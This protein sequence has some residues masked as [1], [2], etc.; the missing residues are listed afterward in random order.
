MIVNI[1]KTCEKIQIYK[2]LNFHLQKLNH[3]VCEDKIAIQIFS[4]SIFSVTLLEEI[5][6]L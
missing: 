2:S 1:F 6:K 5:L 4:Y 3:P